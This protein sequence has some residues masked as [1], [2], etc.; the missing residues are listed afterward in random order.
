MSKF[1][2]AAGLLAAFVS[3]A[4][5][6]AL[7]T[8][9]DPALH[10]GEKEVDPDE[11]ILLDAEIGTDTASVQALLRKC[12]ESDADLRQLDSLIRQLGSDSFRKREEASQKLVSLGL[13]ALEPLREAST[14][15]ELEFIRRARVCIQEIARRNIQ[16]STPLAAVRVLVRR[17]APGTV[18]A[19]LAYVPYAVDEECQEEIWYALDALAVPAG[20]ANPAM[21]AALQDGLA[22]RRAVAG[23]ILGRQGDAKQKLAV[24]Q[25]LA[26]RDPMVRLRAAQGLLAGKD[27]AALP[28][29]VALLAESSTE[30][31]WQAEE[32]LHWVAGE[33]AP[34][35]TIGPGLPEARQKCRT[36]WEAW[37]RAH[38]GKVDWGRLE[39]DH[40]RP[41]LV[42]VRERREE[43]EEAFEPTYWVWL[44][45]CD[46]K[47]RWQ[48]DEL[49][50]PTDLQFL[51]GNR[52][53][54][55]ETK[56]EPDSLDG[57]SERDLQG[58]VLWE[59]EIG[60]G[61]FLACRRL[62][63]GDTFIATERS[64]VELSPSGQEN[65]AHELKSDLSSP[66]A[67]SRLG[68]GRILCIHTRDGRPPAI[69]A[70]LDCLTGH[71]LHR[72]ELKL[73]EK[74]EEEFS[75]APLPGRQ[76]LLT[77][78]RL[79]QVRKLDRTGKTAH[80]LAVPP[81]TWSLTPLRNGNS[82][83]A[84]KSLGKRL[85][86]LDNTGRTVWEAFCQCREAYVRV[87]VCFSLVRLGFDGPRRADLN[88][89]SPGYRIKALRSRDVGLRRWSASALGHF[90]A[91]G[92]PTLLALIQALDDRDEQVRA[93]ASS[94]LYRI[95]ASAI[96]A[97]TRALRHDSARVRGQAASLLLSRGRAASPTLAEL[98]GALKDEDP[99]VRKE[100]A[101]D[102]GW[103][104]MET[105]EGIPEI[106][107]AL[108]QAAKDPDPAVR[109]CVVTS[110]GRVARQDN[111]VLLAVV[112][113]LQDQ[114]TTVRQAAA[115]ALADVG[116]TA[117]S[118]V[119]ALLEALGG[120]DPELRWRAAA[121]L[122]KI[123]PREKRVVERLIETLE[124]NEDL[125]TR[126][127]AASALSRAGSEGKRAVPALLQGLRVEQVRPW[128]CWALGE[129]KAEPDQVVPALVAVL[130]NMEL[131]YSDRASAAYAIGQFGAAAQ[132]A[133]PSLQEVIL[134]LERVTADVTDYRVR[135]SLH[136]NAMTALTAIREDKRAR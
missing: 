131:S 71:E 77:I 74:F 96:P 38:F 92:E 36:A 18:E 67:V 91:A 27:E 37:R 118:A 40:R 29:L 85:V 10:A 83:V 98:L 34:N 81:G 30:I 110:L 112:Q 54:M 6:S 22:A 11:Q 15:A 127:A 120:K 4:G 101:R 43:A 59:K 62:P 72:R 41:G 51:P 55:A 86:E 87:Q 19:L 44:C 31:T 125:R 63:H 95:G 56:F 70:E 109:Q 135:E 35:V 126:A 26:D 50:S 94:S 73:T 75:L 84:C 14:G 49:R 129:I 3:T 119:P 79:G 121:A 57:I 47:S 69:V 48:L 133:K 64:V 104:A 20:K 107:H 28:V 52:V 45:G 124:K 123:S 113:A 23:C 114:Q 9:G 2:L 61:P 134:E 117:S 111:E 78:R 116:L 89:D 88:L 97:L 1:L 102:L 5:D 65:Y 100:V 130:S 106:S 13:P 93:N 8:A 46:G 53:L 7:H 39:Q 76:Y 32:L 115:E 24:R 80:D 136:R 17:Q 58:K 132:A 42:L 25:L 68:N 82:L 128:A 60:R 12:A 122:G 99:Y 105:T 108:L 103:F 33:D 66:C 90:E 21:V 16:W